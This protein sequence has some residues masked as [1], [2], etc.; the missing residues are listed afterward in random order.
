MTD[1]SAVLVDGPWEHRLVAAN[2]SRFHVA[3]G[4]TTPGADDDA[5]WVIL[6]HGFPQHWW[7]W[8]HQIPALARAGY[9]VAAMDLRGT[10]AS[11]K[12]PQGYGLP[13]LARDVAGVIRSLGAQDAVVVGQ[14][15]GGALAWSMPALH[16]GVTRAVAA[17][18][19]PHPL[20]MHSGTVAR[21]LLTTSAARRLAFAQLPWFP[22]RQ[23]T[24]RDLTTRLLGEW[25]APGWLSAE[26]ARVYREAAQVPF[27]A[28]SSMETLRWLVRSTPRMDGR[29][30]LAALRAAPAVP[31]L[32]VHG[33]VD[34]CIP[35]RVARGGPGAPYRFE[36]VVGAG[37]Y[38]AEEAPEEVTALL[39][40]WLADLP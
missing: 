23:L 36:T 12:P 7:A 22:E 31:V 9:R 16:P 10:G 8:R 32:Q 27:A 19:A 40:D 35:V 20:R 6:L 25:G 13:T 33:T 21:A 11:D 24:H 5:P 39:L 1:A 18:S 30:Y 29:R 3:V 15:A 26:E 4:A 34:R 14:G 37:H 38:L 17:L 28:H 2:G